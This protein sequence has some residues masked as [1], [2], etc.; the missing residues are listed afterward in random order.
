MGN[1]FRGVVAKAQ[2]VD[3]K[4]KQGGAVGDEKNQ[5]PVVPPYQGGQ[6]R[7]A[8]VQPQPAQQQT[9]LNKI[10]QFNPLDRT[11][12]VAQRNTNQSE[13]WRSSLGLKQGVT[14]DTGNFRPIEPGMTGKSGIN[15]TYVVKP[16]EPKPIVKDAATLRREQLFPWTK[17]YAQGETPY[18]NIFYKQNLKDYLS[19]GANPAPIDYTRVFD[20]TLQTAG[21]INA[22]YPFTS[23]PTA[24][25]S[26]DAVEQIRLNRGEPTTMLVPAYEGPQQTAGGGGGGDG[27]GGYGGYGGGGG[28]WGGGYD[29]K[30][31][32]W[33][34]GLSTWRI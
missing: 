13:A 30:L 18:G 3:T 22:G 33:Y 14:Y 27:G 5:K 24:D 28:G 19:T 10:P 11:G 20:N 4:K 34:Y 9:W 8:N 7:A 16:W 32:P 6:S 2:K 17:Q 21:G 12:P 29:Q 25:R 15:T 1:P 31:P 26:Y 23:K